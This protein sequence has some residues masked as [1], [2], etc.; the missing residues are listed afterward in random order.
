MLKEKRLTIRLRGE[1]YDQVKNKCQVLGIGVTP[2]IKIFLR[3]F[4]TQQGVGFYVGNDDLCSLL[5]R[6]FYKKAM[7]KGREGC[8]PSSGPRLK[9]LY[10]LGN[11]NHPKFR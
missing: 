2:L 11:H 3:S 4:V 10:Q 7:Q 8:A 6:W 1:L 5:A 9:D